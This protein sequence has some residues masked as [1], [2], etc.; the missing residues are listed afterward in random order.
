MFLDE[1]FFVSSK[2][3]DGFKGVIKYIKQIKREAIENNHS[4]FS[5]NFYVIG[6]TNS[7]KSNFINTLNKMTNKYSQKEYLILKEDSVLKSIMG[8]QLE[9]W[10]EDFTTVSP[11]PN[12][13]VDFIKIKNSALNVN[14]YDTPGVPNF[15]RLTYQFENVN[16][17]K[18]LVINK[19]ISHKVM[20]L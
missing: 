8:E 17:S 15:N 9:G 5:K 6:Y 3:G 19:P 1:I 16:H 14:M 20:Q 13:T 4:R 18:M 7:G 12:T 11:L 2:T 10:G